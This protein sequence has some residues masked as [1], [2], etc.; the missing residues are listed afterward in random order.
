MKIFRERHSTQRALG[1]VW[2]DGQRQGSAAA[3]S[4]LASARGGRGPS[5]GGSTGERSTLRTTGLLH[6]QSLALADLEAGA[7]SC[8]GQG[9]RS[10]RST[11][12]NQAGEEEVTG[13]FLTCVLYSLEYDVGSKPLFYPLHHLFQGK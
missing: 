12:R 5:R 13:S 11:Q 10:P 7:A 6:A 9:L 3:A 8:P 1:A 4:C 2:G